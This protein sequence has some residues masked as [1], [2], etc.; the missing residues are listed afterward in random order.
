[1]EDLPM[2][3]VVFCYDFL[4]VFYRTRPKRYLETLIISQKAITFGNREVISRS[5]NNMADFDD[6]RQRRCS[7]LSSWLSL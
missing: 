3:F 1:M 5:S 7:S 4:T 2:A 6:L